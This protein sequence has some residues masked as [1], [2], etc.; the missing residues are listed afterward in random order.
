MEILLNELVSRIKLTL[1]YSNWKHYHLMGLLLMLIKLPTLY[2]RLSKF[3]NTAN[4]VCD[5]YDMY[6]A[7]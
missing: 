6:A 5:L 1:E 7:W 3:G 4:R 2:A